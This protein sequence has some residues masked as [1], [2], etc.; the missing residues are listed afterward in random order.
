MKANVPTRAQRLKTV[1][2]ELKSFVTGLLSLQVN[3][4]FLKP[5]DYFFILAYHKDTRYILALVKNETAFDAY[6][7]ELR[8]QGSGKK[9]VAEKC[10]RIYLLGMSYI[11]ASSEV[12]QI[13]SEDIKNYDFLSTIPDSDV[14]KTLQIFRP[15]GIKFGNYILDNLRKER[16]DSM[17]KK[18]Q[19][20]K[21][22]NLPTPLKPSPFKVGSLEDRMSNIFSLARQIGMIPTVDEEETKSDYKH[23]VYSTSTEKESNEEEPVVQQEQEE[24]EEVKEETLLDKLIE[25]DKAT[26][27]TVAKS[28]VDRLITLPFNEEILDNIK[29]LDDDYFYA[30]LACIRYNDALTEQKNIE[31]EINEKY[32]TIAQLKSDINKLKHKLNEK[33]A[34]KSKVQEQCKKTTKVVYESYTTVNEYVTN[35]EEQCSKEAQTKKKINEIVTNLSREE[36]DELLKA[37]GIVPKEHTVNKDLTVVLV[38]G[39]NMHVDTSWASIKEHVMDISKKHATPNKGVFVYLAEQINKRNGLT[40]AELGKLFDSDYYA[41][42]AFDFCREYKLIKAKQSKSVSSD[43]IKRGA[44]TRKKASELKKSIIKQAFEEEA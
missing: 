30:Q 31:T 40:Q 24:E 6:T 34:N 26:Q 25:V 44:E 8:K 42:R 35:L 41:K 37:L 11:M 43:A 20:Q 5:N 21:Q 38:D 1:N 3:D 29:Q 16:L 10:Q 17:R 28:F 9:T 19:E 2:E 12:K 4:D 33:I 32:K 27:T 39:K 14:N 22:S 18:M 23:F 15:Y 7:C 13:K 36:K